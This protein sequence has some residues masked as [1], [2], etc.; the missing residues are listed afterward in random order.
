MSLASIKLANPDLFESLVTK[1]ARIARASTSGRPDRSWAY[2]CAEAEFMS[3]M[4]KKTK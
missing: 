3:L 1:W 4:K 2:T